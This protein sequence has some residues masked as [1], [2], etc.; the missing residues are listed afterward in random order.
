MLVMPLDSNEENITN[1]FLDRM[2][3]SLM[4]LKQLDVLILGMNLSLMTQRCT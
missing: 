1:D 4:I 3:I 2:R